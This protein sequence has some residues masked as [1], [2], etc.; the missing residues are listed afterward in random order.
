MTS[1]HVKH[2]T[3]KE[4]LT[5]LDC[6][7]CHHIEYNLKLLPPASHLSTNKNVLF[8]EALFETVA[9]Y[10]RGHSEQ[11][12]PGLKNLYNKFYQLWSTK[13]GTENNISILTRDLDEANHYNRQKESTY[14]KNGYSLLKNFFDYNN[15][16]KQS[17][18]AS[19]HNY[20]IAIGNAIIDGKIPLIREVE[21]NKQREVQLVN[22]S[23]N[24]RYV[25]INEEKLNFHYLMNAFAFQQTLKITPDR[26]LVYNLGRNSETE[27]TY[28]KNDYLRLFNIIESFLQSIDT[29]K[30]YPTTSV[31]TYTTRY[32]ELCDNYNYILN[33]IK[34][35]EK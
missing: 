29:V 33:P 30:P 22:F 20:E 14:V 15:N 35:K 28:E 31:H 10:Y 5:Y 12:P 18:I 24:K 26:I 4:I 21:I 3:I 34:L 7:L 19:N 23:T 27:I 13:N 9:Y 11:N 6:S 8:K 16:M 17:I 25:K 1:K 2:Y 32:K